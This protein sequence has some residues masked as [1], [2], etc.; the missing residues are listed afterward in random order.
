MKKLDRRKQKLKKA[1]SFR[2]Q[3]KMLAAT[4]LAETN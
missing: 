4:G 1:V 2:C 3:E